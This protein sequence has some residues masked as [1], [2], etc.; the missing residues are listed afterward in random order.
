[1]YESAGERFNLG[2]YE[3]FDINSFHKVFIKPFIRDLIEE[4]KNAFDVPEPLMGFSVLIPDSLPQDLKQSEEY[5]KK[6]IEDLP[7]F[8]GFRCIISNGKESIPPVFSGP[9]LIAQYD[10]FKKVALSNWN[11]FESKQKADL[12]KVEEQIVSKKKE[13]ELLKSMLTKT[14]IEEKKHR[15]LEN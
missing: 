4:I 15:R 9:G 5:G 1:M 12:N 8:Y 10:V 6:E 14:N 7:S 3:S 2:S 11:V 13:I